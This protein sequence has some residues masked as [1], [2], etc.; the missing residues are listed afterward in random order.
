MGGGGG[1]RQ[2]SRCRLE[3]AEMIRVCPETESIGG[4][5]H[6]CMGDHSATPPQGPLRPLCGRGERGGLTGPMG[7][8]TGKT[9]GTVTEM[10]TPRQIQRRWGSKCGSGF[11][12]V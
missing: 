11:L 2:D 10:V 7:L 6:R 5:E 8:S 1:G 9:G 4:H 3:A 12:P